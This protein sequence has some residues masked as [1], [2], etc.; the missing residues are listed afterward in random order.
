M[1]PLNVHTATGETF[2]VHI[3]TGWHDV[4]FQEYLTWEGKTEAELLTLITSLTPEH[5]TH[6]DRVSLTFL[7]TLL[8]GF[9]PLPEIKTTIDIEA[10]SLAQ[11]ET[12]RSFYTRFFREDRSTARMRLLPIVYGVYKSAKQNGEWSDRGSMQLA[13]EVRTLPAA[14]VAPEA[15]ALLEKFEQVS[16]YYEELTTGEDGGDDAGED[17]LAGFGF[18]PLLHTLSGGDILKH[19]A[20]LKQSVRKVYTHLFFLTTL[21]RSQENQ[22]A[23]G[24]SGNYH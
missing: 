18:Y 21:A 22:H 24:E 14:E 16:R 13:E 4:P 1:L 6:L 11:F 5:L 9:T 3:R 7:D 10:E 17:A 20:L 12:V 8:T 2:T 19:E 15:L 23:N